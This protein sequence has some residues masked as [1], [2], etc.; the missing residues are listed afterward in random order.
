MFSDEHRCPL[1]YLLLYVRWK[2]GVTF[3]RR[4][5]RD[6]YI[7]TGASSFGSVFRSTD[8]TECHDVLKLALKSGINLIDVAPWYGHGKA[9]KVLGKV[10]VLFPSK[11]QNPQPLVIINDHQHQRILTAGTLQNET[12]N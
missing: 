10:L 12:L 4:C 2:S 3:V 11:F 7:F 9:E 5:F 6:V 8:D 1:G